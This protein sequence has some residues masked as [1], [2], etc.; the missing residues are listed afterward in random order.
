MTRIFH[1]CF[2]LLWTIARIV[3]NSTCHRFELRNATGPTFRFTTDHAEL[4]FQTEEVLSIEDAVK[5]AKKHLQS[6]SGSA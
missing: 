3:F 1:H 4:R 2:T 5:V 6:G